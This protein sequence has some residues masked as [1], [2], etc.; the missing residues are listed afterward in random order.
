MWY[1]DLIDSRSDGSIISPAQALAVRIACSRKGTQRGRVGTNRRPVLFRR[2][3]RDMSPLHAETEGLL[4]SGQVFDEFRG[5]WCVSN[6][7]NRMIS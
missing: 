5:K 1:D 3:E 7:V 6:C 4:R 2:L